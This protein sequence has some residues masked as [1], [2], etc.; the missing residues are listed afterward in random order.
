MK[1]VVLIL[2][3]GVVAISI[4]MAIKKSFAKGGTVVPKISGNTFTPEIKN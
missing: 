1:K 3:I 2:G 4:A